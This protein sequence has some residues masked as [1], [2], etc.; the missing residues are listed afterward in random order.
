MRDIV[1]V[2]FFLFLT[3]LN[4]LSF[5]QEPSDQKFFIAANNQNYNKSVFSTENK[6]A[7]DSLE[8]ITLTEKPI[9]KTSIENITNNLET[10][11]E[12]DLLIDEKLNHIFE[13]INKYYKDKEVEPWLDIN[14][15]LPKLLEKR[16]ITKE[17]TLDCLGQEFQ[18]TVKE[19]IPLFTPRTSHYSRYSIIP[20]KQGKGPQIIKDNIPNG[21]C[22]YDVVFN[23]NNHYQLV[24]RPIFRKPN[25]SEFPQ[26][27]QQIKQS[28]ENVQEPFVL[29]K[30]NF[31]DQNG[32]LVDL[33]QSTPSGDI[34]FA[35]NGAKYSALR[36]PE[37][38]KVSF[39]DRTGS[40]IYT[41]GQAIIKTKANKAGVNKLYLEH[42]AFLPIE[43]YKLQD[44][45]TGDEVTIN[46]VLYKYNFE[47]Y[48]FKLKGKNIR[49]KEKPLILNEKSASEYFSCLDPAMLKSVVTPASASQKSITLKDVL[50]DIGAKCVNGKLVDADDEE[51]Y[52]YTI[53][54][55]AIPL[56]T[57]REITNLYES[58]EFNVHTTIRLY[59]ERILY[60]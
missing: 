40:L 48:E 19:K 59:T 33:E 44:F 12:K 30:I 25:E 49:Y 60:P 23:S 31:Y 56:N 15:I 16:L 45:L 42:P 54:Q 27:T 14:K 26:I 3:S 37:A 24:V 46:V 28:S 39:N 1:S 41:K 47:G 5:C 53:I 22:V 32:S 13:A 36:D 11:V 20:F 52:I 43:R 8:N 35:I 7:S 2:I 21:I 10:Q 58:I 51:I 50:I 6:V 55:T 57:G 9:T 4:A 29:I 18:F 38:G 34:S 17:D